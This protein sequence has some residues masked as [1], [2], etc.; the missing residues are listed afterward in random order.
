MT[1]GTKNSDG[2]VDTPCTLWD[3]DGDLHVEA[4]GLPPAKRCEWQVE[5]QRGEGQPIDFTGAWHGVR[6]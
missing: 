1:I 6:Q 5:I 3:E 2:S 4:M